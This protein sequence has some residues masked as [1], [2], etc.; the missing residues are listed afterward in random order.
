MPSP[1]PGMDP[2]L[3]HPDIFPDFHDSFITHLREQDPG[4][5]SA[6]LH[7]RSRPPGVDRGLRA[8]HR[9]R[10]AG[11]AARK[12]T[13][14]DRGGGGGC[15]SAAPLRAAGDPRNPRRTPRAFRRDLSGTRVRA[16]TGDL[17]RAAQ[18][19]QQDAGRTRP[20]PVPPQARRDSVRQGPSR[21]DRSA[22][23][24]RTH[25]RGAAA[26]PGK[27]PR[28]SSNTT[29]RFTAST[30]WKI[31]SST[32]SGSTNPCRRSPSR[33]FPAIRRCRWIFRPFSNAR[34]T[35]GRITA[36][37]TTGKTR[38]R[39]RWVRSGDHG[40]GKFWPEKRNEE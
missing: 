19:E 29:S 14:R 12:R 13:R 33:C 21:G 40:S 15:C 18:P 8:I 38:R 4:A 30:I 9:S 1:F 24:R 10:R 23:R 22:S 2:F 25:H 11:G 31:S 32:R 35:P 36:K 20:G 17:H 26:S 27:R 28:A 3:E 6:A 5:A 16:A 37:S 7:C 39:R 34:T